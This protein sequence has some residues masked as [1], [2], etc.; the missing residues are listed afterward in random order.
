MRETAFFPAGL[1]GAAEVRSGGEGEMAVLRLSYASP[2][3]LAPGRD[4]LEAALTARLGP[5]RRRDAEMTV[6][7]T[8]DADGNLTAV[9]LS[10]QDEKTLT[11]Q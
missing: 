6:W 5:P 9:T 2:Q 4:R 3:D 10:R 7:Q 1:Y 11:L 8:V